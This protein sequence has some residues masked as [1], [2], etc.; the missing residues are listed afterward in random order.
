V[1]DRI[2]GADW[3][4]CVTSC[5]LADFASD[6]AAAPVLHLLKDG[7][8]RKARDAAKQLCKDARDRYL[9]LLIESNVGLVRGMLAKGLREEAKTVIDYLET[10]APASLIT[11]LRAEIAVPAG[12]AP[13]DK[14]VEGGGA[15][16]WAVTLRLG[17]Q[18][19]LGKEASPEDLAAV[20]SLV[21]DDFIP[22]VAPGNADGE[23]LAV[24]LAAARKACQA[25]GDGRWEDAK[26]A[27]R[28]LPQHSVFRHWRLFL[29]GVRCVFEED[30]ETA[31][32]CLAGLPTGGALAIAAETFD[33]ASG[34]P[35]APAEA[36]VPL[37]L[38][39]TGQP[40]AWGRPDHF[41]SDGMEGGQTDQV[42]RD[43]PGR[44]EG[45]L[46]LTPPGAG[47]GANRYDPAI[48]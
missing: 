47:I 19:A 13:A 6:P 37:L 30:F 28:E 20:D 36:R 39:A 22:P 5:D 29:R 18:L 16:A 26:H 32:R 25:T 38:A 14:A 4:A 40:A 33:P 21:I 24:E 46:P 15:L 17:Q 2:T 35:A 7:K 27:L 1:L 48:W 9:P 8:W 41:C 42:L 34:G 31:R 12:P 10:I 44:L 23:R 43:S 45:S 11:M 3:L